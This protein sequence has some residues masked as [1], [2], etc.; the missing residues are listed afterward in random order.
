[1]P[2]ALHAPQPRADAALVANVH[3]ARQLGV[4]RSLF[5]DLI[6]HTPLNLERNVSPGAVRRYKLTSLGWSTRRPPW[7]SGPC[8]P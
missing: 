4:D 2:A 1:M 6:A 7:C 8:L 3:D 5:C